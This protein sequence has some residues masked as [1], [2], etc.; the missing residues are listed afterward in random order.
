[1]DK[2]H[3]LFTGT[4]YIHDSFGAACLASLYKNFVSVS[5]VER[6]QEELI[7]EITAMSSSPENRSDA[8]NVAIITFNQPVVKY[9]SWYWLGTQTYIKILESY[10]S[11]TSIAG[12][13]L[14]IDSG[15]GQVYG[16]PEFYD[17]IIQF[18][19]S[20]PVVVYAN[21]YLCSGAY[22]IAAASDWIV[23]NKRADAV[24]SIG[25]YG[26]IVDMDGIIE[27]LGGKVHTIYASESTEKNDAYRDVIKGDYKK[28]IKNELDP[29][30]A[31]FKDDMLASRPQLNE[32]V[33]KG[34]VWP[35]S[36]C[37]ALGL[38]D[39][40]GTEADAIAKVYELAEGNSNNK[41][42]KKK[43]MSKL[44]SYPGIQKVLG[45]NGDGLKVIT[46]AISGKTGFFIEV[47]QLD[48][49][50][51]S[52]AEKEKAVTTA[53]GKATAA[54]GKVTTI[55]GAINTAI[56]TA[57]LKEEVAANATAEDKANL[58]AAKVVE[59][60]KQPGTTASKSKSDGDKFEEDEDDNKTSIIDSI[61]TK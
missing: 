18:R 59:Y 44:V 13:V 15:G 58:L 45:V 56:E 3:T 11:D 25:A 2:L 38:A 42:Q 34:G 28:Y 12:I 10:R 37:V 29:I 52:I 22:Y 17:Y 26:T 21:G 27:K 51:A 49:L 7:S 33:F 55:E 9:D 53:E 4:F 50:E 24:G 23:V 19:Q 40:V 61:N 48:A 32:K 8:L 39:E 6:P 20:K 54:E 46:K 43:S 5:Y 31:T 30:V 41:N 60:G 47:A 35:G 14:K 1:M 16:T 36:E 57:E